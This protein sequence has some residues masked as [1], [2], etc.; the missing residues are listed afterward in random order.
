MSPETCSSAFPLDAPTC[1]RE[2]SATL[3]CL[4]SGYLTAG[5]RCERRIPDHVVEA[6]WRRARVA[7]GASGE[8]FFR[9]PWRGGEW[10]AYGHPDGHVRGVYCPEH[11]AGRDQRA[12]DAIARAQSAAR[13]LQ[14]VA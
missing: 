1:E 11:A 5:G 10:L 8:G 6:A 14:P 4:S 9:F 7:G 3:R 2:A 12:V 13:A